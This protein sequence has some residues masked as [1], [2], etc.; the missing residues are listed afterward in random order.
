MKHVNVDP[1][2]LTVIRARGTLLPLNRCIGGSC[3]ER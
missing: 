1:D 2:G 3:T